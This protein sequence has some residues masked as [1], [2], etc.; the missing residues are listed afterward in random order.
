[1]RCRFLSVKPADG[2]PAAEIGLS[3]SLSQQDK[4]NDFLIV[5]SDLQGTGLLDLETGRWLQIDMSGNTSMSGT[6][7]QPNE[8]GQS[9]ALTV[10]GNG[11]VEF[12]GRAT[13]TGS[14]PSQPFESGPLARSSENPL[15]VQ[16]GNPLAAALG[17]PF[18]GKFKSDRLTIEIRDGGGAYAGTITMGNQTFPPVA[19]RQRGRLEG[20]FQSQGQP[21]AFTAALRGPVLSLSTGGQAFELTKEAP[22]AIA[23]PLTNPGQSNPL[24][25]GNPIGAQPQNPLGTARGDVGPSGSPM[26][27]R[28][29]ERARRVVESALVETGTSETI[30]A[31]EHKI[32][33]ILQTAAGRPQDLPAQLRD[34]VLPNHQNWFR[35]VFGGQTGAVL[36][37]EYGRRVPTFEIDLH[38]LFAAMVRE[39][40]TEVRVNRID[41]IGDPL[42]TGLQNK[43]L[44]AMRQ[45]VPL[46][47]VR[48]AKPAEK[49][50]THLWSF[51]YVDG[52]FRLVGKMRAINAV[53]ASSA[54]GGG[55]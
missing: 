31:L 46:Y 22:A 29:P 7:Q 32:E 52:G 9:I 23:N 30:G 26:Q 1:M 36:A 6:Q 34:L 45:T 25:P 12:H 2:R 10:N 15:A 4:D 21:F 41:R 19:R 48:M 51:V 49:R 42:A 3:V 54:N 55:A 38:K 40:K 16:A 13:P 5:K 44:A 24:A 14:R 17:D 50:S 28:P 33:T 53:A 47:S 35:Q 20:S 27:P 43:L 37:Q 39:G 18:V 8:Y 11:R